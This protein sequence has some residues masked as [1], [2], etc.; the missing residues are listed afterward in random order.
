MPPTMTERIQR[1]STK[2]IRCT[3]RELHVSIPSSPAAIDPLCER[4]RALLARRQLQPMQFPVEM[5]ARECLNNAI[6]HGNRG[7]AHSRVTLCVHIGRK[8][9]SLRVTDAGPG[10]NWRRRRRLWWPRGDAINGRGLLIFK[11][12]ADGVIFNRRGNQVTLW[13]KTA[14]ESR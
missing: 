6:L 10:F 5:L 4:I 2:S 7:R 14:K 8:R 1:G 13:I 9:I 12:Y 3:D 11:M